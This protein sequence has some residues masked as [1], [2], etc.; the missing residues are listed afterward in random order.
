M[1]I[2]AVLFDLDGTL[3]PLEQEVFIKHYFGGLVKSLAA[4]GYEPEK[5]SR[6]IWLGTGA[7]IEN[8]GKTTNENVFWDVF[9]KAY[10]KNARE[11][12]PYFI[13]FYNEEFDKVS[14]VAS[15]NPDAVRAV[16]EIKAL[17]LRVVLATNP[18]FPAVATRKRTAWAGLSVDEFELFTSYE[19]SS[20]CKPNLNYYRE[21]LAKIGVNPEECLMVG[22]DVDDDM[23][24][25]QLGMKVF[26]I[27]RH[28]INKSG[29]DISK[30]PQGSFN[31]LINY[32]KSL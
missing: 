28:L 14:V 16:R 5:L 6:S 15:Q 20:Y 1:S 9:S 32:V 31:D 24:T 18:V 27:P 10:G 30:Y 12:E 2:K 29:K 23:V 13:K 26:L 3:L 8:D 4:H 11:D 19:N 17:G 21:I 25:E 22:N 7:M